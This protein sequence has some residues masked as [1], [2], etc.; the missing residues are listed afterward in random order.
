LASF[1]ICPKRS[2]AAIGC[3]RSGTNS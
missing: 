1:R 3:A 2:Y